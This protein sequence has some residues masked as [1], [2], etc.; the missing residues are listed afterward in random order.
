VVRGVQET[1]TLDNYIEEV[2]K[3]VPQCEKHPTS[4]INGP[5]HVLLADRPGVI[6]W[7]ICDW[8]ARR[9]GFVGDQPTRR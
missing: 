2:I 1:P 6:N 4:H 5:C 7:S 9:A 3:R 8:R